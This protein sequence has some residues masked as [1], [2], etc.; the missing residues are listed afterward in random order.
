MLRQ[1]RF[2]HK[3]VKIRTMVLN[4]LHALSIGAGLSLQAQLST[5]HGRT[6]L[7]QLQLSPTLSTQRDEWL[8]L[9]DELSNRILAAERWLKS[10]AKDDKQAQRVQ[11]HPGVGLL[12]SL[13][14]VHTPL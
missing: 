13:C 2:R 6:R 4:S 1:L 14:L 8:A 9:C 7:Q 10:Q 5:V 3:L 12:T 11:T